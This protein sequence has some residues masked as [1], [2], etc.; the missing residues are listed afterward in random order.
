MDQFSNLEHSQRGLPK[1]R[2]G[3]ACVGCNKGRRSSSLIVAWFVKHCHIGACLF[4]GN[5][6]SGWSALGVGMT[7]LTIMLFGHATKYLRT[8]LSF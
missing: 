3:V 5:Q 7:A 6:I 2:Q 8:N 1:G 4:S